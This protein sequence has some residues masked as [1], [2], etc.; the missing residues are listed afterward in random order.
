MSLQRY[1]LELYQFELSLEKEIRKIIKR[2]EST[3]IGLVKNRLY[4]HGVD[5]SG[6][7][8][9]PD[10]SQSTINRK[11]E[12]G[13]RTSHVTLRDEGLFYSGFYTEL[14]KDYI[15]L[16]NSS[17]DKT[18]LL[19]NKYGGA[20]LEFTR[21]EQQY[22]LNE[23]IDPGLEKLLKSLERNSTSASGTIDLDMF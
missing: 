7:K 23:I 12:E 9:T 18:S 20:I 16:L 4:Q 10:Y 11:R 3:I 1:L 22:I 17:D 19:V 6:K 2:N 13:K 14:T 21:Q 5:G 15:L 8:I